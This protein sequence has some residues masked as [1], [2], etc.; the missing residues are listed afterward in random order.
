[1]GVNYWTKASRSIT[2]FFK[3]SITLTEAVALAGDDGENGCIGGGRKRYRFR[4]CRRVFLPTE[5]LKFRNGK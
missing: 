2:Y 3:F 5:G 1:M 4:L